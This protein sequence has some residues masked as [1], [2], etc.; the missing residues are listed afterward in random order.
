MA[1]ESLY[2]KKFNL[3][4]RCHGASQGGKISQKVK[5][6]DRASLDSGLEPG[7]SSHPAQRVGELLVAVL[8]VGGA[9]ALDR[10]PVVLLR[11]HDGG[12]DDQ[13]QNRVSV[14][15]QQCA[16]SQAFYSQITGFSSLPCPFA[17]DRDILSS[18]PK[19]LYCVMPHHVLPCFPVSLHPVLSC[20]NLFPALPHHPSSTHP[21]L[22]CP[23]LP[24]PA[25]PCPALPGP[26][27]PCPAALTDRLLSRSMALSAPPMRASVSCPTTLQR[28]SMAQGH[29]R[30]QTSGHQLPVT[31]TRCPQ[32]FFAQ[33]RTTYTYTSQS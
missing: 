13:Q 33:N 20:T 7:V 29:F 9:P 17:P 4:E 26:A 5:S 22:P 21:P 25:R 14:S 1:R 27:L 3:T 31:S 15:S 18:C 2:F 28:R 19:T 30:S 16:Q 12:E 6:Q 10:L 24:G 11:R 23:A 32:V 8:E